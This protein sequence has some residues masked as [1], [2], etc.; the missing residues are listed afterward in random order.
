MIQVGGKG[1]QINNAMIESSVKQPS[2]DR[3]LKLFSFFLSTKNLH[4][5]AKP[6]FLRDGNFATFLLINT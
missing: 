2:F 6:S 4:S 5:M 3:G 1:K